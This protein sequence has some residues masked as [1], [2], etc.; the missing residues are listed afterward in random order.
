MIEKRYRSNIN[1]NLISLRNSVPSLRVMVQHQK[2]LAGE[3]INEETEDL[4]GLVAAKKT[5]KATILTKATE[6]IWH[7]ERKNRFLS[8]ENDCLKSQIASLE[9]AMCDELYLG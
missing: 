8:Q 7:L 6:Y 1:N 9:I 3:T 4:D 5:N 2:Q